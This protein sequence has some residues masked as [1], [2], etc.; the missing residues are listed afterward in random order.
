[1]EWAMSILLNHPQVLEK[2]KAEI[3]IQV[4]QDRLLEDSDLPRLPYLQCIVSETLRMFPVLPL[5][6][7]HLSSQDCQIGGFDIPGGTMLLVNAWAIHR[8]PKLWDEPEVFKPCVKH[9][10]L[11]SCVK[12]GQ[13]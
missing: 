5:L 3:D 7:P 9:N 10:L 8:D 11:R 6:L 2:A 13:S 12:H 1:M 4:G